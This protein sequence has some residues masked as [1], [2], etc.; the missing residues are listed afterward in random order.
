MLRIA[1]LVYPRTAFLR[2]Q[3]LALV[4]KRMSSVSPAEVRASLRRDIY[5]NGAF[6]ETAA[7]FDVS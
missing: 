7:H 3:P 4:L 5:I 6:E 1:T 2:V